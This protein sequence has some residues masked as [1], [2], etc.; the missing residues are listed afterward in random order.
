[1]AWHGFNSEDLPNG[2]SKPKGDHPNEG[3]RVETVKE[4]VAQFRNEA[5]KKTSSF[6][7]QPDR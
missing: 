2:R 5:H 4:S 7:L 1:M 3:S 6:S